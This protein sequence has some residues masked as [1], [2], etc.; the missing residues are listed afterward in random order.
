MK[1]PT[2]VTEG[3][4]SDR[5]GERKERWKTRMENSRE[6]VIISEKGEKEGPVMGGDYEKGL[7]HQLMELQ[8][9]LEV[10]EEAYK[11]ERNAGGRKGH[12]GKHLSRGKWNAGTG[13]GLRTSRRGNRDAARS[14][15]DEASSGFRG[16]DSRHGNSD[17][18]GRGG[19]VSDSGRMKGLA[20]YEDTIH[21]IAGFLYSAGVIHN[22]I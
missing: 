3:K 13:R 15:C 10:T 6:K 9:R 21:G 14:V 8:A 2:Y 19:K 17:L 11:K 18:R 22:A 20:L 7:F 12:P 16:K 5:G 1:I 4:S